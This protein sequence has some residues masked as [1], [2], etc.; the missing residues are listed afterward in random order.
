MQL[1]IVQVMVIRVKVLV[2]R[3]PLATNI[4]QAGMYGTAT[5]YFHL[6]VPVLD[7]KIAKIFANGQR[8]SRNARSAVRFVRQ[9][10]NM[11]IMD[12]RQTVALCARISD[13]GG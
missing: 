12:I 9:K 10:K 4:M 5:T 8:I 7:G 3:S 11:K 1:I 2:L 13:S 6:E